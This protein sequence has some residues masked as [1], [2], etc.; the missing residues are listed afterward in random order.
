MTLSEIQRASSDNLR[1]TYFRLAMSIPDT[2][3]V[4]DPAYR[5]CLGE[6]EHPICNFAADLK[7]DPWSGRRLANLAMSRRSFNVYALPGDEPAHV[8]EL[9]IRCDFRI[10]YRLIQMASD[11]APVEPSI[12]MRRAESAP[13]RSEIAQFMTDQFFPR[14]TSGFRRRIAQA[15]ADSQVLDLYEMIWG[16]QRIGGVML[17][18]TELA[19]GIY[20]LCID[21]PR[22]GQG[23]GRLLTNW[24]LRQASLRTK[25]AILQCD[26]HLQEWYEKQGFCRTGTIDVYTLSNPVRRDIMGIT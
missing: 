22:R 16:D 5:A 4:E 6:F 26:P 13:I 17:Y 9:L 23:L 18:E 15:T 20:N 11:G 3:L 1:Q 2:V 10:S 19:V 14:Q 7:L 8:A 21:F 25:P 24:A 12:D